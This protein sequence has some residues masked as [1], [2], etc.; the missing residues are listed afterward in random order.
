MRNN[1]K[2]KVY[3]NRLNVENLGPINKASIDFGDVTIIIGS[4]NTGKTYLTIMIYMLEKLVKDLMDE[5]IKYVLVK[6]V[7]DLDEAIKHGGSLKETGILKEHELEFSAVNTAGKKS[8]RR[9]KFIK[10][11]SDT[12]I[13]YLKRNKEILNTILS[14]RL[15]DINDYFLI[16]PAQLIKKGNN[17]CKIEATFNIN[18]NKLLKISLT[19][20]A[21]KVVSEIEPDF[22]GMHT[23]YTGIL[24]S[25]LNPLYIPVLHSSLDP[26]YIPVE[27]LV[28]IPIFF[29][30]MNMVLSLYSS[31][32]IK[33]PLLRRSLHDYI[34]SLNDIKTMS[35]YSK[36]PISIKSK[37]GKY[38][39]MQTGEILYIDKKGVEVPIYSSSS[40]ASQVSGIILPL[41]YNSRLDNRNKYN[42]VIIEEPEINL[43]ADS[44]LL[45]AEYIANNSKDAQI[46]L[47]THSEYVLTKLAHLFADGKIR[48]LKAYYTD[49]DDGVL[50]QLDL[51]KETGEV[52]LPRSIEK[53]TSKLSAEALALLDKAMGIER[54][55]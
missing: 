33:N 43:H 22:D 32:I 9:I 48:D 55:E 17:E 1:F 23:Y 54:E 26:L 47:T 46:V 28:I 52:E 2:D 10:I 45:I 14:N 8:T 34:Q 20:S 49:P 37:F 21:T 11:N 51:K 18:S 19:I 24:L 35:S 27:R 6:L 40:G 30:F 50:K 41:W 15:S 53:V 13:E 7:K 29:Q 44:Q 39:I 16:E 38:K 4:Q 36:K 5:V 42:L 31:R 25:Q 3:I 12:I